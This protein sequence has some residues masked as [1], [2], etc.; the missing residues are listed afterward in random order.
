[1][2]QRQVPGRATGNIFLQHAD[3]HRLPVGRPI[4]HG[5]EQR[6]HVR[7]ICL[8]RQE[9]ANFK[10]RIDARLQAAEQLE[11]QPPPVHHATVALVDFA[12][13][14][15]KRFRRLGNDLGQAR[16]A[17]RRQR[18]PLPH[19][20]LQHRRQIAWAGKAL[21]LC[22]D[23]EQAAGKVGIGQRV[24]HQKRRLARRSV[25]AM[26]NGRRP[27]VG[28]A[29][30]VL[31]IEQH[32]EQQIQIGRTDRIVDPQEHQAATAHAER[33]QIDGFDSINRPCFPPK[34]AAR[35]EPLPQARLQAGSE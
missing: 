31:A 5:P 22:H 9:S 2:P 21:L 12:H 7:K 15:N 11:E 29:L 10:F 35:Y 13:I 25:E 19:Q 16:I 3:R 18:A 4:F 32:E 17:G 24:N 28:R 34:P 26:H 30:R 6:R 14:G 23:V 20:P 1:M 27:L 33:D 8:L